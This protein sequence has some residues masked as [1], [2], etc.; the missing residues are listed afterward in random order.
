M[1]S[2]E[3]VDTSKVTLVDLLQHRSQHCGD[4]V[5][6]D[7]L[8]DGQSV[9]GS[10]TYRELDLQARK[11]AASLQERNLL[12]ERVLLFYPPGLDYIKAFFGCLYAGV[13]AVPAYPPQGSQKLN[14]L[15]SIIVNASAKLVLTT[16]AI[17][18]KFA[19]RLQVESGL[20]QIEWL[21]T[22]LDLSPSSHWQQ[23]NIAPD[24]LAFLQYTS[25]STGNPKGVMVSHRNLLHNLALIYRC[26]GHSSKSKG[27]IWLPPYH[28]MGLIGGILQPLYGA[29][30]V[31]LMPPVYFLQK[32]LRWLQAI[33]NYRGTTSGGPNFAYQLCVEKAKY[34]DLDGLDLSSWEVA[35]NGAE[36]IRSETIKQFTE[37]FA[38]YG[39]NPKAFYPCYGMAE[40][41]LIITGGQ[42]NSPAIIRHWNKTS[43]ENRAAQP[44][45]ESR[46]VSEISALVSSGHSQMDHEV[47]IVD[48]ETSHRCISRNIGEIWVSGTSVAQGYW[49]RP[50]E[51]AQVFSA[52]LSDE[53]NKPFM[54]T[55]DL[56]FLD[57]DGELFVVGRLKDL[58]IIR[59]Q[60]FYPHDIETTVEESHIAL[61]AGHGAAVSLEIKGSERLV[62]IQ[63]VKRTYL[64]CL[65]VAEV[66]N[67]VRR[68]VTQQHQISPYAIV[69]IKTGSLPKTSSGKVKRYACRDAFLANRL[70]VVDD[71]AEIPTERAKFKGLQSDL[72]AILKTISE[73][74]LSLIN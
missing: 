36:P 2:P 59:G 20:S 31:T 9:S 72:D 40:S 19:D 18:S 57:E 73:E 35:F 46:T 22:D 30:P 37:T 25:G 52:Y 3:F 44:I 53:T 61:R 24:T 65:N 71:W 68:A 28:D 5:A 6:Y 23:P 66:V 69:L 4:R 14:R 56:G 43:L 54:R 70:V 48:P 11:L 1:L 42:K 58:L 8:A 38:P 64:K 13:I 50:E 45:D 32:P 55:G 7:F 39:F 47:I 17:C 34:Q 62:V 67:S 74:S 33:S 15:Q 26:F 10:L 29:F 51:T 49:G 63:E 21:A 12:G 60:N 27:V 16:K 41:T